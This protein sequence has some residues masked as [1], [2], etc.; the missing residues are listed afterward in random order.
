MICVGVLTVH[1]EYGMYLSETK[2]LSPVET[3]MTTIASLLPMDVPTQVKWHMRGLLRNGGSEAEVEYA[4]ELA[5]GAVDVSG[6]V[7]R[8]GIPEVKDVLGERLF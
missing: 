5:K 6:L 8:G 4:L 7:L 1:L 3:S 2:L